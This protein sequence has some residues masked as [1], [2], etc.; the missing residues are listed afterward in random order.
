[1][2]NNINLAPFVNLRS[3]GLDCGMIDPDSPL[4]ATVWVFTLLS[5]ITSPHMVDIWLRVGVENV[6]DL[7]VVDWH[8]MDEILTQPQWVNLLRLTITWHCERYEREAGME[9]VTAQLPMLTSRG[10]EILDDIDVFSD[11]IWDW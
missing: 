10:V 11:S 3:V 6:S 1:M 7:D 9:L 5:Q 2:L 8:R 4:P